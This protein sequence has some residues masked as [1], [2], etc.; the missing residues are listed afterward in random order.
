ML[1]VPEETNRASAF[2]MLGMMAEELGSCICSF[3]GLKK[4]KKGTKIP[5]VSIGR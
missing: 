5:F 2:K 1:N 4:K 3:S